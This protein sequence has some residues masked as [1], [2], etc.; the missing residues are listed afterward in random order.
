[1][2]GSHAGETSSTTRQ[3]VINTTSLGMT[4]K[5][6]FQVPLDGLDRHA[7]VTDLVYTPLRTPF[8]IGA[9][10]RGCPHRRRSWH[11]A[12]PGRPGL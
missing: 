5:A 9:E 2:N 7:V 10:A 12:A 8:L 1:M 6:D 3:L 11:V 4:G